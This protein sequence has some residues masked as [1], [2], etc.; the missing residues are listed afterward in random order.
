[1]TPLRALVVEDQPINLQLALFVLQAEGFVVAG[2]GGAEEAIALANTFRPD[3]I[4]MDIQMPE[5]AG[6]QA[7]RRLR[8]DP[9]TR[10]VVIVA[11]TAYAM[12]GDEQ[13]MR[14][15]GCDGYIAKPIDVATFGASVREYVEATRSG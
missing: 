5:I 15:A 7:V 3:V 2:V 12:K 9:D 4:L 6:L 8:A 1:M 13:V 14:A 11:F 10:H